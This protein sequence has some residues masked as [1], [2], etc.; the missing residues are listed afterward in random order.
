MPPLIVSG[1]FFSSCFP[2][3]ICFPLNMNVFPQKNMTVFIWGTTG[4]VTWNRTNQ[5]EQSCLWMGSKRNYL[6]FLSYFLPS[7]KHCYRY[8]YLCLQNGGKHL[9]TT[10]GIL[11]IAWLFVISFIYYRWKER[12]TSHWVS[13]RR[14]FAL[15]RSHYYWPN[16]KDLCALIIHKNLQKFWQELFWQKRGKL[17]KSKWYRTIPGKREIHLEAKSSIT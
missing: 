9:L 1:F 8:P 7:Y 15:L 6:T 11:G 17:I 2:D 16:E 14:N 4:S 12:S 13:A 5:T 10:S 3:R